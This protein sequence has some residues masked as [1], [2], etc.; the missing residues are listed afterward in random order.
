MR[1]SILVAVAVALVA[2][3]CADSN[4]QPVEVVA[5]VDGDL[6][7]EIQAQCDT[8]AA[9]CAVCL[10]WIDDDDAADEVETWQRD[11]ACGWRLVERAEGFA[12]EDGPA[13][14]GAAWD[15]CVSR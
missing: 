14:Y 8:D 3:G 13:V 10:R 5:C 1:P 4:P 6:Q 12:A 11:D 15:A 9:G 7:S 2:V